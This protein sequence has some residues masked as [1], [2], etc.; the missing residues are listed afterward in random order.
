MGAARLEGAAAGA[1]VGTISPYRLH[2]PIQG[3]RRL[4]LARVGRVHQHR[5]Q[6]PLLMVQRVE[7]VLLLE[8]FL[9]IVEEEEAA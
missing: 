8:L 1:A 4:S 7:I 2:P 9:D 6:A 3:H 5:R